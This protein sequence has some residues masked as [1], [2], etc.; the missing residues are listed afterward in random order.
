MLVRT[1]L[2][3]GIIINYTCLNAQSAKPTKNLHE[4]SVKLVKTM[5]GVEPDNLD[6]KV[7]SELIGDW[8]AD[9]V[10]DLELMKKMYTDKGMAVPKE[11]LIDVK[12]IPE[13][14]MVWYSIKKDSSGNLYNY[15]S[16]PVLKEPKCKIKISTNYIE[17]LATKEY[18]K[19][20]LMDEG[21]S[22]STL[23][24]VKGKFYRGSREQGLAALKKKK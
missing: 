24:R 3:F 5:L 17:C 1:I 6:S 20:M 15:D 14:K 10:Q 2:F 8:V 23:Y 19:N 21:I 16:N 13:D 4:Q 11:L 12:N 7:E 18:A 22:I 9:H